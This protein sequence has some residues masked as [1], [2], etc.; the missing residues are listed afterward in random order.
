MMIAL[1]LLASLL[2]ASAY[3]PI[4]R[5]PVKTSQLKVKDKFTIE[6]LQLQVFF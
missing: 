1:C 2:S 5:V 6:S 3:A 4:G